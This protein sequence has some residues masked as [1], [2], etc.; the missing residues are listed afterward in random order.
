MHLCCTSEDSGGSG[1]CFYHRCHR[2]V[3]LGGRLGGCSSDPK[4]SAATISL[5][6]HAFTF[7][8]QNILCPGMSAIKATAG[9]TPVQRLRDDAEGGSLLDIPADIPATLPMLQMQ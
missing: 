9:D 8:T 1:K 6:I 7:I 5:V 2:Y 4:I 3:R